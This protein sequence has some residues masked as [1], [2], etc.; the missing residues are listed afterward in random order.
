MT[1]DTLEKKAI[2]PLMQHMGVVDC[3]LDGDQ[4]VWASSDDLALVLT[5]DSASRCPTCGQHV[6]GGERWHLGT[7]TTVARQ[8]FRRG[9]R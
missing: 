1:C 4:A 3:W 7:Q 8:I 5:L 2:G 9:Y 6:A